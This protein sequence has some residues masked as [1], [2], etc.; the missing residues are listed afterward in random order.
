MIERDYCTILLA[1]PSLLQLQAGASETLDQQHY[2]AVTAIL[3]STTST[4]S[5]SLAPVNSPT[6][7]F[8]CTLMCKQVS[9]PLA[10]RHYWGRPLPTFS[11]V[12]SSVGGRP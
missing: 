10:N 5:H 7:N 3:Q 9:K 1:L 6:I 12:S 2:T 11:S 4:V 8:T